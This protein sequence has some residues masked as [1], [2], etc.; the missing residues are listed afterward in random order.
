M[1]WNKKPDGMSCQDAMRHVH[2][3]GSEL[4]QFEKPPTSDSEQETLMCRRQDDHLPSPVRQAR[5]SINYRAPSMTPVR[6]SALSCKKDANRRWVFKRKAVL[7]RIVGA[8]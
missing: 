7:L 4:N 8:D 2:A 1:T 6:I 3:A 5:M